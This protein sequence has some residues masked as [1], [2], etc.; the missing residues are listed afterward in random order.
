[1]PPLAVADARALTRVA[2]AKR[3]SAYPKRAVS[4]R[5]TCSRT[6]F[7]PLFGEDRT[8]QRIERAVGPTDFELTRAVPS[9]PG[10]AT[11]SVALKRGAEA[12]GHGTAPRRVLRGVGPPVHLPFVQNRPNRTIKDHYF[13]CWVVASLDETPS[14]PLLRAHSDVSLPK[15]RRTREPGARECRPFGVS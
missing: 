13:C 2:N 10:S 5:R 1:M 11:R 15:S 9:H 14:E 6:E 8:K 4:R 3:N 7:N 12:P